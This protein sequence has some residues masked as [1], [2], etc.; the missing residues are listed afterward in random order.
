MRSACSVHDRNF[1]PST[2]LIESWDNFQTKF[3]KSILNTFSVG[4]CAMASN[5]LLVESHLFRYTCI[6][7]R[8]WK[9]PHCSCL[10]VHFSDSW[11]ESFVAICTS[12]HTFKTSHLFLNA[13]GKSQKANIIWFTFMLKVDNSE[14]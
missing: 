2:I 3:L 12:G 11:L 7:H 9:M 6:F 4:F 8:R 13:F 14:S 1:S 10:R 5:Y